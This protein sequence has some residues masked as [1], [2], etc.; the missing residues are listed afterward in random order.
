MSSAIVQV[1]AQQRYTLF[2]GVTDVGPGAQDHHG[3]DC[4]R[5]P[6][7][8]PVAGRCCVR[9]YRSLPILGRRVGKSHHDHDGHGPSFEA[10]AGLATPDCDARDADGA[11]TSSSPR[12]RHQPTTDG[13]MRPMFLGAHFVEVEVEYAPWARPGLPH[14]WPS[15]NPGALLIRKRRGDQIRGAVLQGIGQALHEDLLYDPASGQPLT[16]GLL[17]GPAFDPSRRPPRSRCI[18][19]KWTMGMAPFG[20]KT[21]GEV[22]YHSGP[23]CG[24]RTPV[25]NATGIR[26]TVAAHGPVTKLLGGG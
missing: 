11:R 12:R 18:F 8:S 13:K 15:M 3:H 7:R 24:S 10:V 20:A 25:F 26:M 17:S 21:I 14:M 23:G 16:T 1:D 6:R 22:W 5:S 4:R 2:V 19:W 9:R